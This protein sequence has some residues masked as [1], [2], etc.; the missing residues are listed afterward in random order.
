LRVKLPKSNYKPLVWN[1]NS[2]QFENTD[3]FDVLEQFHFV[4]DQS[5]KSFSDWEMFIDTEI[6]ANEVAVV[7]MV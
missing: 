3:K 6:Q 4:N 2:L 5:S 1:K 7:M